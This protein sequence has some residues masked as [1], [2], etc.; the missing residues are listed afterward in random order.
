MESSERREQQ[1]SLAVFTVLI[2]IIQVLGLTAVIL[3]AV[4]MGSFRGG[5]AWQ[6]DPAHEF[7]YHPVFM[8]TGMIF[9]YADAILTYRVFR[10]VKKT[11]LKAIHGIIQAV[12]L[13]LSGVG[14][15][16]VFDSHNLNHPPIP[17]LYSLHSWL[18]IVTV[19]LFGLQWMSGLISFVFPMLS[20]GARQMYM[21]HHIFWGLAILC[22]A[23]ASALTGITEKA[24]FTDFY[25]PFK[26]SG[27]A[28][29]TYIINFLG[30]TIACLV[31]LVVYV[32]TRPEYKRQPS[33]EEEHI[34]LMQ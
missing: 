25:S 17:N 26:Y 8:V 31:A 23:G 27:F 28:T 3:V 5:F 32:V 12:V 30:L 1:G 7:N 22:L 10:N 13:I 29:E 33:P 24:L 16:A 18:G 9:L 14:L 21:P 34:Q 11:Y 19:I 20:M 4:W 15:K 6:S 2:L